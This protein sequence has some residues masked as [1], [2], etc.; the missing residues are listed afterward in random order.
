MET[1]TRGIKIL[2]CACMQVG[3]LAQLACLV[4]VYQARVKRAVASIPSLAAPGG[5][6]ASTG[7]QGPAGAPGAAAATAG[8]PAAGPGLKAKR[9]ASASA[10][11]LPSS[12]AG[13]E[14]KSTGAE[15]AA[16]ATGDGSGPEQGVQGHQGQAEAE[17]SGGPLSSW[18][19]LAGLLAEL[20]LMLT[21]LSHATFT[22]KENEKELLHIKVM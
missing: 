20:R 1:G 3:V 7:S 2:P 21:A 22:C 14:G 8:S 17:G 5:A 6:Q 10:F 16:A 13:E 9:S 4:P 12:P 11:D 15:D 18:Q 19:L